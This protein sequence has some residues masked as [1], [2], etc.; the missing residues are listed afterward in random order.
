MTLR[1]TGDINS[2]R[3][4]RLAQWLMYWACVLKIQSLHLL[5]SFVYIF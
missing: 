5:K 1:H 3:N 4:Y 2:L